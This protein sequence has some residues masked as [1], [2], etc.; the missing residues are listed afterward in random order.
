MMGSF[1]KTFAEQQDVGDQRDELS[2]FHLVAEGRMVEGVFAI[3][4]HTIAVHCVRRT[5]LLLTK[6]D[7]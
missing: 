7:I 4:A 2:R 1:Y 5:L 6:G 3:Q